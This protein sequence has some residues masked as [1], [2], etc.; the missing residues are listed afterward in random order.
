MVAVA[1]TLAVRCTD[2]DKYYGKG[3]AR[4][5]ALHSC[6]LEARAGEL[7]MLVG[8]SGCGKTTL[9]S[10][11]VGILDVDAGEVEVFGERVDRM[12]AGRKTAFRKRMVGFAF[13]QFNL[14][15]T[16]TAMENASLPLL[17]AG[18][19]RTKAM[20]RAGEV[21]ASMG[22]ADKVNKYPRE[23]SGGQQQRIA[24][25]RALVHNPR[26]IVCDEPTS[27]LDSKTGEAV[28]QQLRQVALR[29]DRCVIVVTHDPRIFHHAD[30]IAQME[31][32]HIVSVTKPGDAGH[33]AGIKH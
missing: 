3:N 12:S 24:F 13:Q 30:R 21:L 4:T 28:M 8:P 16:L 32:G 20:Q 29:E 2:V 31:D 27:A 9:L 17:I 6:D 10:V 1:Q 23:L 15:P 11:I 26:L 5:Q 14:L 18:E 33:P 19:P 22:M 7:L 25:S